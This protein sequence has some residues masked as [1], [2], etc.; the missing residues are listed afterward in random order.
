[1]QLIAAEF[2]DYFAELL[3]DT[4]LHLH[5]CIGLITCTKLN[6][7]KLNTDYTSLGTS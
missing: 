5:T 1:M 4:D 7:Q 3:P 6:W 2:A